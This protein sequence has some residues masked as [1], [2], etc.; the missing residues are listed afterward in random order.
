MRI[1][2][3]DTTLTEPIEVEYQFEAGEEEVTYYPDGSGQPSSSPQVSLIRFIYKG[4]DITE[5]IWEF[6][7]HN[8]ID[9]L[10]DEI[11]EFEESGGG[12]DWEDF[13]DKQ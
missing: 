1:W 3:W 5:L 4:Q 10:E 2:E 11:T 7:N 6:V 12:V 9:D 8:M 13:W